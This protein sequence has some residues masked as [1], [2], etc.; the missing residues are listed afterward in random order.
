MKTTSGGFR[1]NIDVDTWIKS[2][3]TWED[4]AFPLF[5]AEAAV[6]DEEAGTQITITQ[7]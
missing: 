6:S 4:W 7:S 1:V 2:D 5:D 3:E